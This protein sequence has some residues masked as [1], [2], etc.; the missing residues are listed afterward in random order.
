MRAE[1]AL[2]TPVLPPDASAHANAG[3]LLPG[4]WGGVTG[5]CSMRGAEALL[6]ATASG[7]TADV[8]VR[9]GPHAASARMRKRIGA[10]RTAQWYGRDSST[11]RRGGGTGRRVGLKNRCPQGRAGSTP[12]L[13]TSCTAD[14]TPG[15]VIGLWHGRPP[16]ACSPNGGSSR[17]SGVFAC[18]EAALSRRS[19]YY[20]AGSVQ[21]CPASTSFSD[22]PYGQCL[23]LSPLSQASRIP[24]VPRSQSGRIFCD[25]ARRSRR[26]S[27]GLGRPQYQ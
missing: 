11:G 16:G 27:S 1:I 14:S 8:G 2:A 17:R 25:T 18:D 26:R 4:G 21:A 10:T 23:D 9:A 5:G 20:S 3:R 6:P 13:G 15:T 24:G 12:A 22:F 19:G 7:L